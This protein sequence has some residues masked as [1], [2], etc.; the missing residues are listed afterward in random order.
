METRKI[1]A[2]TSGR[3]MSYVPSDVVKALDLLNHAEAGLAA[4][5]DIGC[6][7]GETLPVTIRIGPGVDL[8][9]ERARAVKAYPSTGQVRLVFPEF[10]AHAWNLPGHQLAWPTPEGITV[11]ADG[12]ATIECEVPDWEPVVEANLL[13]TTGQAYRSSILLSGQENPH[14][15]CGV[16]GPLTS[17][18]DAEGGET[19]LRLTLDCVD[20]EVV[21]VVSVAEDTKPQNVVTLHE[22]S[23]GQLHV[24][25]KP[26]ALALGLY[27]DLADGPVRLRWFKQ[28][29]DSLVVFPYQGGENDGE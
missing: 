23:R 10:D 7:D 14:V 17:A 4:S 8:A 24:S 13:A 15:E 11:E 21:G 18:V 6:P 29:D 2:Q 3:V 9:D 5:F 26:F 25:S 16:P 12:T 19:H 1:S 27:D 22:A 28:Q 20:G